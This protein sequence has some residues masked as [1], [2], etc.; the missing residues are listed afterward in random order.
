MSDSKIAQAIDA[1]IRKQI[2]AKVNLRAL[3]NSY[4]DERELAIDIINASG[5]DWQK[6]ADGAFL[7]KQTIAKLVKEETKFPRYDTLGRIF[8]FFNFEVELHGVELKTK[9]RN[10]PKDQTKSA[11]QSWAAEKAPQPQESH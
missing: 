9:Y 11:G 5:M 6:V 7:T 1:E 10:R 3:G 8:R 2:S 4:R